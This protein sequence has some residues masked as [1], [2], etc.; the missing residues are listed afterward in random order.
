[1]KNLKE[2]LFYN[3]F[4]EYLRIDSSLSVAIEDHRISVCYIKRSPVSLR[5]EALQTLTISE[6]HPGPGELVSTT[7]M[8]LSDRGVKNKEIILSVPHEWVLTTNIELPGSVE[9]NLSDV[10][11]YEMDRYTPFSSEQVF[12]DYRIISR[13]SSKIFLML[14][15]INRELLVPIINTYKEDGFSIKI[16]TP[17]QTASSFL[18]N[19]LYPGK[20]VLFL[21]RTS[22]GYLSLLSQ[23]GLPLSLEEVSTADHIIDTLRKDSG[24]DLRPDMIVYLNGSGLQDPLS[25]TGIPSHDL[26]ES[27]KKAISGPVS[28]EGVSAIGA[29]LMG[30]SGKETLNLLSLGKRETVKK[31]VALSAFLLILLALIIGASLTLPVIKNEKE[32]EALTV[33]INTLKG[34]VKE[35]EALKGELK[36]LNKKINAIR[37]FKSNA[38]VMIEILKEVTTLLP[39]D[40]WLTRLE[41]KDG[42]A[43]FEGFSDSATKLISILES[44]DIFRNV[45]FSSTTVKDRRLNKERFRIKAELEGVE[46]GK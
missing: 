29:S 40:T 31:P 34:R 28:G 12:Y 15:L 33:E 7:G 14:T 11:S 23:K 13:D 1:M 32:V 42:K 16:V 38:P 3:P 20:K 27:L 39:D 37:G 9:E 45:S 22:D 17:E 19:W 35:V 2:I 36:V 6:K 25:E 24:D 8:V 10:L 46:Q 43:T 18:I 26:S 41:V 44:S 30:I 21:K 5:I 4:E